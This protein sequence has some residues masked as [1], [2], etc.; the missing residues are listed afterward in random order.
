M[1]K[2]TLTAEEMRLKGLEMIRQAKEK[3]RREKETIRLRL[4]ELLERHIETSFASFDLDIF[5]HQVA[6][7]IGRPVEPARGIGEPLSGKPV[8]EE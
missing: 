3:D 6:E 2:R 4:G 1:G 8:G 5:V 7:V